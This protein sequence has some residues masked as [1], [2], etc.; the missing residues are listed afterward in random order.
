MAG[1]DHASLLDDA[2]T[3]ATLDGQTRRGAALREAAIAAIDADADPVRAA[4]WHERLGRARWLAADTVGALRAYE[5]ALAMVEPPSPARA[6][7][8]SGYGQLLMLLDRW[9]ESRRLCEEALA[10]ARADGDRQVEGHALCTLGLDYGALGRSTEG[11]AALEEALR[12]AVAIGNNDDIGRANV[13]LANALLYVGEPERA[14]DVVR[15]GMAEAQALGMA[16]SYGSYLAHTGVQVLNDLGRWAEALELGTETFA[17][18]HLEPHSDRYGLARLVPLLVSVGAPT[19][20]AR[21]DQLGRLLEGVPTEGQ[22]WVPYHLARAEDHLWHGRPA[23]ALVAGRRG[24]V[25]VD[26]TTLTWYPL[27]LVR[28]A[29]RAAAE[30]AELGRARRD[31]TLEATAR[32]GF[33]ELAGYITRADEDGSFARLHG[34]AA[35]QAQAELATIEAERCRVEGVP[36]TA[37]WR[38]AAAALDRDG[39][40][41]PLAYARWRLAEALLSD[42]ERGPAAAELGAAYRIA[43]ELGAE[44]LRLPSSAWPLALGS[45]SRRTMRRSHRRP[46]PRPWIRSG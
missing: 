30:L 41:Y 15:D 43:T 8:L 32:E 18:Q 20:E 2:S 7:V 11:V 22:F 1:V 34:P 38:A 35:D 16:S 21:L 27:R 46:R 19:A 13:N 28:T 36:Q 39:R 40:P 23:E 12:I 3:I 14:A 33:S 31:R 6:R 45:R 5:A 44:P 4:L 24:L 10:L 42:G 9:D 17:S 25:G 37:A 29:A 26:P